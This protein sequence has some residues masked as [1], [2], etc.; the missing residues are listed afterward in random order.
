MNHYQHKKVGEHSYIV[1]EIFPGAKGGMAMGLFV[2][3]ERACIVDSGWGVTGN[4]R[5]YVAEITDLP[6][7]CILTHPH[8]DHA[9]GSVWFDDIYMNPLDDSVAKWS[10]VKEKRLFDA[11][12]GGENR[13]LLAEMEREIS[14]CSQFSYHNMQDGDVFDLG[15]VTIE[16]I[17]VPGHTRGSMLLYCREDNILCAGDDIA[18]TVSL[19][20]EGHEKPVTL[21]EYR[22][23][24]SNLHTRMQPDPKLIIGH[25]T[26]LKSM[27][28]VE[29]LLAAC[30]CVL[31]GNVPEPRVGVRLPKFLENAKAP[32]TVVYLDETVFI[33]S[34]IE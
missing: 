12:H 1:T 18:P 26:E 14:D 11:S 5:E 3:S 4:L 23:A 19:V 13:E 33:Y 16:A 10:L 17:H 30:D 22:T 28:L 25:S 34:E 31:S 6:A 24:L 7:F 15:G 9:G 21:M 8:P 29:N 27:A 2:G 20:G 32:Y